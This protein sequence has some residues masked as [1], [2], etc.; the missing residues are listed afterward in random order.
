M[1]LKGIS[2]YF[3]YGF[4][5]GE[6]EKLIKKHNFDCIITTR[7]NKFDFQN[8]KLNQQVM[9]C[10]KLGLKLSSLHMSY[11]GKDLTKFWEDG[12]DG[13]ELEKSLI[14]DV[15]AAYKYGFSCVVVHLVGKKSKIGL[16]RIKRVLAYCEKYSIPLAIENIGHFS[17][18]KYVFDSIDSPLLKLCFD[19]GHQ[20]V[21]EKNKD[22]LS[23]YGDKLICLHLHS[24]MGEKDEHTL[25][26]YGNIDWASFAKRIA[27]INPNI[28]LDYEIFMSTR[29]CDS[30]E[31]VLSEVYKEACN[32]EK[33]I[34]KYAK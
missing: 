31:D 32:L 27:K 23:V 14:L 2:L 29:H 11:H 6:N 34:E 7:D 18:M 19:I 24:N 30:A 21:F 13:D 12:K 3:G 33:M 15:K 26:K 16:E 1:N 8:G 25:A 28:N 10:K 17:I 9:I 4:P 20:N 5:I 22:I